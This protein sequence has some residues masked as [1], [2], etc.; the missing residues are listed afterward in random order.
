MMPALKLRPATM[1]RRDCHGCYAASRRH[2]EN[3]EKILLSDA[4]RHSLPFAK[5]R[6]MDSNLRW[7]D[8]GERG[9]RRRQAS[10]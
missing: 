9:Q 6:A 2:G 10:E 4:P 7:N 8:K 5:G 3:A 1:Q